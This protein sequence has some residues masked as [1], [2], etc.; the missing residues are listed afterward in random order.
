MGRNG[1]FRE[2]GAALL[3]FLEN[4]LAV[5]MPRPVPKRVSSG[6]LIVRVRIKRGAA[7]REASWFS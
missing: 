6:E 1:G 2:P 4:H 7:C 5:D 3:A